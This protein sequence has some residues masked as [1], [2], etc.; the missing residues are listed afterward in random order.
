[1]PGGTASLPLP[2]GAVPIRLTR[3]GRPNGLGAQCPGDEMT[4]LYTRLIVT[5]SPTVSGMVT[6]PT[7]RMG[8][9]PRQH[10]PFRMLLRDASL[11]QDGSE[12]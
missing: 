7:I 10:G 6:R 8:Y 4:T 12:T 1:M 2:I 9:G 5:P 3:V 11:E